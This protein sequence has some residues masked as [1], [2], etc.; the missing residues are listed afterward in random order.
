[1]CARARLFGRLCE[2]A[3]VM[4]AGGRR[5]LPRRTLRGTGTRC[6]PSQEIARQS[7][8]TTIF[9]LE[10]VFYLNPGVVRGAPSVKPFREFFDSRS[11]V[12]AHVQS[13]T[14]V[15]TSLEQT[16]AA[17][18]MQ[19]VTA[20]FGA[21]VNQQQQ[22]QQQQQQLQGESRVHPD[23]QCLPSANGPFWW[24]AVTQASQWE[25]PAFLF[26]AHV[27]IQPNATVSI[28]NPY[29]QSTVVVS[30][31]EGCNPGE[32]FS[33]PA[34]AVQAGGASTTRAEERNSYQSML[35]Q[36]GGLTAQQQLQRQQQV[37]ANQRALAQLTTQQQWQQQAELLRQQHAAELQR[38]Q[39]ELEYQADD[40]DSDLANAADVEIYES[41]VPQKLTIGKPHPD[42]VVEA[43]CLSTVASPD[44]SLELQIYTEK[45]PAATALSALQLEAVTYACQRYEL[46]LQDGARA[47]FFIGDGAGMGKGREIA[48]LLA[49]NWLQG[50]RKSL[51]VSI[52]SDLKVD[53]ERDLSDCGISEEYP[54]R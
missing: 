23:W 36:Q 18:A 24:N 19:T 40:P 28:A 48:G 20:S 12:L 13:K 7:S 45:H 8:D 9:G 29:N 39:E 43:A 41:Y 51:W 2:R 4:Q 25:L 11:Q 42:P 54:F 46:T 10:Q 3:C 53:A 34:Q 44:V 5:K 31:P 27:V 47:G 50:R 16:Q 52:S 38:I 17:V 26:S 14:Y 1:M 35:E 6:V 22:Q 33:V 30:F 32:W 37:A 21:A 15:R 49:E